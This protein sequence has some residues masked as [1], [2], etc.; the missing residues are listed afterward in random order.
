MSLPN[1]R[2]RTVACLASGPSLTPADCDAVRAAGWAT[3]VTNTTFRACPWADVLFAFDVPWIRLYLP[4][5]RD[6]FRGRVFTQS[7]HRIARGVECARR[8]R[9]FR[10]FGNSGANAIVFA[11]CTGATRIVLLGYDAA[12][13]PEGQTHH[14][15]DHPA[16][17][18]NC[19]SMPRWVGQFER[20][21]RF[22]RR[23][24][25]T[26][27]NASRTTALRCFKLG[28]LEKELEGCSPTS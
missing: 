20:V 8:Y 14:H 1:W 25:A 22:A 6:T 5:I 24:D 26:I 23:F 12:K 3:I 7:I 21:S 19:D 27:V 28:A 17:L 11:L 10:S 15:G 9:H 2:G 16:G 18:Q 13:G 4:E